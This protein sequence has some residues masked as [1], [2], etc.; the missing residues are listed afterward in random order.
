MV[1]R[2]N[3]S[4]HYKVLVRQSACPRKSLSRFFYAKQFKVQ[5]LGYEK[6][7]MNKL[8]CKELTLSF[9]LCLSETVKVKKIT[10]LFC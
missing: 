5:E 7:G 9:S 1:K 8:P 3:E 10:S 2:I 4:R 6:I